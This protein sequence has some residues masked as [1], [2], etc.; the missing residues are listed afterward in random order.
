MN[1]KVLIVEDEQLIRD[2]IRLTTP[3]ERFSCEVAGTAENGL[4]GEQCIRDLE[5]DIVI[6]DICMP[7]QDG[8]AM[9]QNTSFSAAIIL[10]GHSDFAYAQQAIRLG[11]RDYIL[12]PIDDEE[13]YASLASLSDALLAERSTPSMNSQV[14]RQPEHD[15]QEYYI[16]SAVEFIE[17]QYSSDISLRETA[18]VI[19]ISENYLSRLFREKTGY[20][21]LE[22]IRNH[23]L[24][25]ALELMQDQSLRI[26]EIAHMTGF[27]DM[28]YF[29]RVFR[30]NIGMSPRDYQNGLRD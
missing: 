1:L 10:T 11:V 25:C 27:N 17:Q 19:G 6:T 15:K 7:G 24:R 28:S 22:Y 3:W 2:E 9:L 20:S 18:E 16:Q 13:L 21:F 23:R 12:K 30:K 5:P 4:E 29:A 8:I 26:N 14:L